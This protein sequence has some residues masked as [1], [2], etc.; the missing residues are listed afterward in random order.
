MNQGDSHRQRPQLRLTRTTHTAVA[1]PVSTEILQTLTMVYW[2]PRHAVNASCLIPITRPRERDG[3]R[4]SPSRG[5]R[6]RRAG[7]ARE[8]VHRKNARARFAHNRASLLEIA[9]SRGA[10]APRRFAPACSPDREDAVGWVQPRAGARAVEFASLSSRRA[11]LHAEAAVT[12]H[13]S[14]RDVDARAVHARG[15]GRARADGPPL[16]LRAPRRSQRA[17]AALRA[18]ARGGSRRR[19]RA[20][21]HHR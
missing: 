9:R 18:R 16:A 17:A 1:L 14:Y 13:S 6:R 2:R 3:T 12:G 10:R 7:I 15:C 21:I 19:V 11:R 4:A 8:A 5:E 20:E